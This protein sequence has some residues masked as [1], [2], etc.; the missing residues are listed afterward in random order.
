MKNRKELS[1]DH[2]RYE[3]LCKGLGKTADFLRIPMHR[4]E[5]LS[6][7]EERVEFF[8]DYDSIFAV[9]DY[10]ASEIMY[11]LMGK[12]IRLPED[13][14]VIGFDDSALSRQIHPTLSS[15]RQDVSYRASKAIEYLISMSADRSFSRTEKIPVKLILRESSRVI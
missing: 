14:W 15:V 10:Y 8:R 1:P 4:E 13:V 6:F 5:R 2:D 11:F 3:G 9:S 7:Y 12:G